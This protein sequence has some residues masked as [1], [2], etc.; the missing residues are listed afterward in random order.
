MRRARGMALA[1]DD[2]LDAWRGKAFSYGLFL[3]VEDKAGLD[4]ASAAPRF[5]APPQSSRA[6]FPHAAGEPVI[7][8]YGTE[9]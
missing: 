6:S 9:G 1:W 8:R 7:G 5:S 4:G 3:C 2:V